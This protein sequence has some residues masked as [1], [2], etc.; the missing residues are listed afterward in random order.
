MNYSDLQKKT[1][2]WASTF[3]RMRD[4]GTAS[5]TVIRTINDALGLEIQKKPD[6][7]RFVA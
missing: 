2:V 4:R 7:P 6:K 5:E 3:T 1:G